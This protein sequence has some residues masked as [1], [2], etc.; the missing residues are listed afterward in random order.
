MWDP[1]SACLGFGLWGIFQHLRIPFPPKNS[2]VLKGP[3]VSVQFLQKVFTTS[4]SSGVVGLCGLE[5]HT[6]RQNWQKAPNVRLVD[7][8]DMIPGA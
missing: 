3:V 7:W 8:T 4:R 2:K 1:E 5:G 6:K